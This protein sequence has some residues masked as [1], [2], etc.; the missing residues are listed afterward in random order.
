MFRNRVI[1]KIT[2]FIFAGMAVVSFTLLVSCGP[3]VEEGPEGQGTGT[4]ALFL[5]DNISYYKQVVAT[6]NSV[7]LVNSGV[8][9][10][11]EMMKS[12][13][14]LDIAN[15]ALNAQLVDAGACAAGQYNRIDIEFLQDVRLMD[16]KKDAQCSF[17]SYLAEN[18]L[19]TPL[20]CDP[21]TRVCTL[22]I[23]SA[24]RQ[25]GVPVMREAITPL[26]LDF[27]LEQFTVA[28][29]DTVST[30]SV[31][32]KVVPR[33]AA[34]LNT[35]IFAR[36]V[37]GS[38]SALN[39]DSKTFVLTNGGMVFFVDYSRVLPSLQPGLDTLLP[40]AETEQFHVQVQAGSIDLATN[41]VVA[42]GVYAIVE[43]TVS[44]PTSTTFTLT[45][46]PSPALSLPVNYLASK[47]GGE[48]VFGAWVSLKLDGYQD[49][50][51]LVGHGEVLPS[52]MVIE[53]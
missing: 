16:K 5:T 38:I 27:D 50:E 49:G 12:P 31:T 19:V 1:H 23:R 53:N 32:M 37:T 10:V 29:F 46:Q 26:V 8:Q 18:G 15:L 52:G 21:V 2:D 17:T 9:E 11:C 3:V 14:T 20:Q 13:V 28:N 51:Y 22:S 41:R 7:R 47:I 39:T 44:N 25:G 36:S 4:V 40:T 42:T 35:S 43:G 34:E 6:V 48:I 45:Y 24:E 33:D 30:C